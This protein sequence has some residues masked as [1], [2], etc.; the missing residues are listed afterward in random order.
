MS[1]CNLENS[2]HTTIEPCPE[3]S[4]SCKNVA[5]RTLYHQVSFPENQTQ[6]ADH[7]YF[8][9]DKNCSVG[10]FTKAGLII[11]KQHLRALAEIENNKL[12]YCFDIDAAQYIAALKDKSAEPIKN[13]H[14]PGI[15]ELGYNIPI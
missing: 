12:C 7:Y 9:A 6:T 5:M 15:D 11:P 2:E 13:P 3:C 14:H 8:C 4:S 10:Y 1:C